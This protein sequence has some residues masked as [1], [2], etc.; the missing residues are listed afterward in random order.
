M[1]EADIALDLFGQQRWRVLGGDV[2]RLADSDRFESTNENWFYEGK[3]IEEGIVVARDFV[4]GLAGRSV[5]IAFV[6]N[7]GE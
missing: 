6:L 5:Y 4:S 7:A 2:Y 1:S 3:S